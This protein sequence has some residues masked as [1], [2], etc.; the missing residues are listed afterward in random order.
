MLK[1]WHQS[2]VHIT[3]Y[4]EGVTFTSHN[5]YHCCNYSAP[6]TDHSFLSLANQVTVSSHQFQTIWMLILFAS[7]I[8]TLSITIWKRT[9]CDSSSTKQYCSPTVI[10]SPEISVH[11]SFLKIIISLI[12]LNFFI[13]PF[14]SLLPPHDPFFYPSPSKVSCKANIFLTYL[15]LF[16]NENQP[17]QGLDK[18]STSL[19]KKSSNKKLRQI[20]SM[21]HI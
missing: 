5:S 6:C 9:P 17:C 15:P 14:L 13:G 20:A 16:L 4:V 8:L 18:S 11:K 3:K 1:V 21:Y 2:W 10:Q 12:S 7:S 19:I